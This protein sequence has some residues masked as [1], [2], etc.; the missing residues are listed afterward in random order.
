[1]TVNPRNEWVKV[2]MIGKASSSGSVPQGSGPCEEAVC[3]ELN[4]TKGI[5]SE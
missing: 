5:R 2:V 1:M 4:L 3:V